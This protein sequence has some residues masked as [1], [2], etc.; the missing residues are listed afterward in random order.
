M[1]GNITDSEMTAALDEVI[2]SL[3]KELTGKQEGEF[4]TPEYAEK[5]GITTHTAYNELTALLAL[6]K[7]TKRQFR[8]KTVI[9]WKVRN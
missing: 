9:Y 6:G 7:V 8:K 1:A 4:T 2:L 5:C 3:H